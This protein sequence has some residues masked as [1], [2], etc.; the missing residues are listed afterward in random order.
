M[1]AKNDVT[2]DELRS[3][4]STTQYRDNWDLIFKKDK[5]DE[6][7]NFSDKSEKYKSEDISL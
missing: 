4:I 6:T 2:G 5:T 1:T 7:K 3:K